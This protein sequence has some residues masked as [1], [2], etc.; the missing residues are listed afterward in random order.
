MVHVMLLPMINVSHFYITAFRSMCAVPSIVFC[1]IIIII[2]II[3]RHLYARYLQL[4]LIQTMFL[5]YIVLQ[6]FSVY[7][8][9]HDKLFLL[10]Y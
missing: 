5:W 2:I 7:V 10:L 6:L 3:C 9:S 1:I 8:I 4:Y